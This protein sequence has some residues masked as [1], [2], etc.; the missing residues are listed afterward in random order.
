MRET[1]SSRLKEIMSKMNLR[2]VDILDRARPY[3]DK[4][5]VK[6][7]KS[8]LSQYVTGKVL[9]G[10][11]KL[12][13]LG[14]ALNVSEAWL[15]GYDVPMGRDLSSSREDAVIPAGFIPL[16]DMVSVPLVGPIACGTPILAEENIKQYIGIPAAWRADFALECHGDSMAPTIR[17]GD[18]VCI[19]KQSEVETGQIAAVRIGE[20][21]T[22]KHFYRQGDVVQLIAENSAA[23]PP[24]V[25]SGQQ[26]AEIQI[27]G[28]AVGFC[29]GLV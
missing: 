16:P 28:L 14:L 11:E 10:Q 24:M 25:Y 8:D 12:T 2:Q 29:R 6:L 13:V 22:L 19:R 7:S 27:E 1:T 18:I 17:D 5:G 3:C 23:C 9:P 4:Y 26:L 20:E 21:A 15:M